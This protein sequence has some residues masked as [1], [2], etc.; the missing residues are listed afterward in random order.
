MQVEYDSRLNRRYLALVNGKDGG[1]D[2]TG[3]DDGDDH[4]NE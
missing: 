3:E 4:E 2:V 1:K